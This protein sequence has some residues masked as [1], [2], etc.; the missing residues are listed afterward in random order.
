MTFA[1][2]VSGEIVKKVVYDG[3]A[4]CIDGVQQGELMGNEDWATNTFEVTGNGPHTLSWLYVK[5]EEDMKPGEFDCA[6]LDNVTWTPSGPADVVV[7]VN[8]TNVTVSGSWLAE[9]TTRAATDDAA[10]GRKVWQCYV[11]GLDPERAD[12]DFRITRFWMD[13]NTPMFEF[14]HTSDGSGNTFVPRIRKMGSA[15]PSG[16]WQEV[17]SA[18][19]PAYRFFKAEVTLP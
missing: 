10:N 17:P 6:W 15:T 2:K 5:D 12:D 16:P 14:S 3:L 1:C 18:G 13:G 4:F 11:L 9:K 19:N 8:G 7:P